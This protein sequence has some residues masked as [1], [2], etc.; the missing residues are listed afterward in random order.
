V[1]KCLAIL[2]GL[3]LV[4]STNALAENLSD[5]SRDFR[6][7]I[8]HPIVDPIKNHA[9]DLGRRS[10][11]SQT[12]RFIRDSTEP[13]YAPS[14]SSQQAQSDTQQLPSMP[15]S[16]SNESPDSMVTW[17]T[18]LV[19][20]LS[21]NKRYPAEA[22]KRRKEGLTVATFTV[23]H[24][25]HLESSRIDQS[26]GSVILDQEVIDLLNRTQPFPPLPSDYSSREITL[27]IP[28]RFSLSPDKSDHAAHA[29]S[30]S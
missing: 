14:A 8:Q 21:R 22:A 12:L 15:S 17:R 29:R 13:T 28:I 6:R 25:G 24:D 11:R 2:C 23:D 9:R 16:N 5:T 4:L 1:P 10:H 7:N 30:K 20:I 27:T 26:S 19:D 18:Q 3:W